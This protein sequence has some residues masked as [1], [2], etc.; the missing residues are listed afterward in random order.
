[1]ITPFAK[2]NDGCM[3]NSW[4]VGG[5]NCTNNVCTLPPGNK[6]TSDGNCGWNQYCNSTFFMPQ[7]NFCSPLPGTGQSCAITNK[8]QVGQNC[9]VNQICVNYFSLAAGSQC[10]AAIECQT[11]LDCYNG[12]CVT[13]SY[14]FLSGPGVI[15]G[16]DCDPAEGDPGCRCNF[17][18]NIYQYLIE[19]SVTY[20]AAC[21][22]G[23]STF[24][25]CMTQFSCSNT[26]T[27]ALSCMRKNC[28]TQYNSLISVCTADPS[29]VQPH[30]GASEVMVM[31]LLALVMML[32]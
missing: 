6:C 24:E 27:G 8:C 19:S 12:L 5:L 25:K 22:A 28:Y 1:V 9:G 23:F 13:P 2:L 17:A 14:H 18:S 3:S 21:S 15:W 29:L 26:N 32:L 20:N 11:G 7:N 4:C 16:P 31:L 30:C 10:T